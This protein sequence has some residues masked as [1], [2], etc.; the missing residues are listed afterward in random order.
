MNFLQSNITNLREGT[1]IWVSRPE[2]WIVSLRSTRY[3]LALAGFS[4]N[5]L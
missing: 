4:V 3:S 5:I 2:H 1:S